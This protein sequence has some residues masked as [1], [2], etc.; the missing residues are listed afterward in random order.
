MTRK[1]FSVVNKP[2]NDEKND[3][4][5]QNT[6]LYPIA[7][8]FFEDHNDYDDII[9]TYDNALENIPKIVGEDSVVD[10]T[11]MCSDKQTYIQIKIRFIN[12]RI[13]PP[14]SDVSHKYSNLGAIYTPNTAMYKMTTYA[15]T[16]TCD[17]N[18][19]VYSFK[20]NT[21]M[22][23]QEL[24]NTVLSN[25]Y[26]FCF[27]IPVYSKY[28]SL[29][30][31]DPMTLIKSGEEFESMYGY[32]IIEGKIRYL[33]PIFKKPFNSPIV[34][35]N[36]HENQLARTDILY[37]KGF[38]YEDSYYIV[39]SI[40]RDKI[41]S[42]GR[43]GAVVSPPDFIFALQMSD[44]Y[45]NSDVSQ[46]GVERKK[47][48]L[49][50]TVPIRYLFYAFGCTTDKEM[51]EYICPSMDDFALIHSIRNACLQGFKH[52][53][54]LEIASIPRH[55]ESSVIRLKQ[56]LDMDT[57][58]FIIGSIII[59]TEKKE[60][61]LGRNKTLYKANIVHIV[62][63]ILT[64]KFMPGIGDDNDSAFDRNRAVCIEMGLIIKRLYLVGY[65][66]EPSQDKVALPNRR[67]RIGNQIEREF[68][69]FHKS[70]L[71]DDCL[72]EIKRMIT[73]ERNPMIITKN[74]K[75]NITNMF[76]KMSNNIGN[77]LINS[78]KEAN[79]QSK[80]RT[81]VITPKNINFVRGSL[82]ELVISSDDKKASVSWEH[83]TV[84]QTDA[85]FIDPAQ[86]HEAGSSTGRYR[87]PSI[88]TWV[89]LGTK[90]H[91]EKGW[92]KAHK[93]YI[94][95][96]YNKNVKTPIAELYNIKINGSTYG[97]VKRFDYV[98]QLYADLLDARR[99]GKIG[100]ETTIVLNNT[101]GTL[102]IWTDIGRLVTYFV[103][104][105]KC[106]TL[107]KT[108]V[109]PNDSFSKWLISCNA[110]THKLQQG[111]SDGFLTLMDSDMC[112]E[113]AVIAPSMKEFYESPTKYTHI[114][115][116]NAMHGTVAGMVP[117][118]NMNKGVR[119][120]LITNHTKQ[121]IGPTLRYPQLKYQNDSSYLI[122][123]QA[124]LART[125]L[126]DCKKTVETPYGQ[127]V[128]V[129]HLLYKYNQEDCIIANQ[130][131]V[132]SGNFLEIDS[133]FTVISEI[134]QDKEFS[135]PSGCILNGNLD[136]YN[137]INP[138]TA[139]PK[140]VGEIFYQNDVIIAKTL[141]TTT[142]T[143]DV[144]IL[145][146]KPDGKHPRGANMRVIRNV[147][148]NYIHDEDKGCKVAQFGQYCVPI[149]G[150]K[151]N[152]ECAQKGTIGKILPPSKIPYTSFGL[153]PDV[154]FNPPTIFVRET[155]AQVYLAMLQKTCALLGCPIDCTPYHTQRTTEELQEL[156]RQMGIDDK[157]KEI[158]Y[159]PDTGRQ[160]RAHVF[161]GNHYWER[162]P[163]LVEKKINIRNGGPK[164]KITF[165]P[166]KGR[167]RLGGQSIDRMG[168]DCLYSSG[169]H[170]LRMDELLN[171][172]SKLKIGICNRCHSMKSYYNKTSKCWACT[173]CGM[174]PDFTIKHVPHASN[175][176]NHIFNALHVSI[177]YYTDGELDIVN[178]LNCS[179]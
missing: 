79:P 95:D 123:P 13:N 73:E 178:E 65:N 170:A 38:E 161:V 179:K 24:L 102:N 163:H 57:A 133:M 27:P 159:D 142:T 31:F 165:N 36:D 140:R 151:V 168:S 9:R 155:Y 17:A 76:L 105:D 153:R 118:I 131:S 156:A 97:Y 144:S 11:Y 134:E 160:Y 44:D 172:G 72:L 143:S 141:K 135:I 52:K 173:Q 70:R 43:G 16:I 174:H 75:N 108:K 61:I 45:M 34:E 149:V 129:A 171:R 116:P 49:Y 29:R 82:R 148:K 74:I 40:V 132:E 120:A 124:P 55:T 3:R 88:Y 39:A 104:I 18:V 62:D 59:K 1:Q 77:S 60:E 103:N 175:L 37:T 162:Q 90:A 86:A 89:T 112:C 96:I 113:N 166:T 7:K 81:G 47:R 19:E 20:E 22:Q 138:K 114:A 8:S 177:D 4:F 119:A 53:E 115:L 154:I 94:R 99:R 42:V 139:L 92:L 85:F 46:N 50:N 71:R 106:F 157:G 66:L 164:D 145:N 26:N 21:I 130:A 93:L 121:A 167:R 25:A 54:A 14:N 32:F 152:T 176:I 30:N 91:K 98:E 56:P 158:L 110:S 84:N 12:V 127:N 2:V 41:R 137:K 169:I 150:D 23:P 68:K 35:K 63:N 5:E 146:T 67:L 87:M 147:V 109:V 48:R 122:S 128:T 100:F 111:V 126:Y 64:N 117:A 58:K 69:A 78:F 107:T 80:I 136:S 51:L 10:K 83:R 125:C 101:L 6:L 28:C 15:A 33:V